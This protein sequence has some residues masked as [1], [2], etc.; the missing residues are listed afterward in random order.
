MHAAAES[1]PW[2][3]RAADL[4]GPAPFPD[5]VGDALGFPR[6]VRARALAQ[7]GGIPRARLVCRARRHRCHGGF[8]CRSSRQP[9]VDQSCRRRRIGVQGRGAWTSADPGCPAGRQRRAGR[10]ARDA[11]SRH[12]IEHVRKEHAPAR[13][14]VEHRPRAG[15]WAGVRGVAAAACRRPADEHQD[16]GLARA[17]AVV[18]HGGARP[19]EGCRGRVGAAA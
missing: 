17:G 15:G 1:D 5:P 14:R 8:R 9:R 6:A 10:P 18:F 4:G 7:V 16:P 3:R 19:P 13:N 2:I 12:W 11:A